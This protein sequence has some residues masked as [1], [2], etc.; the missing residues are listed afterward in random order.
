MYLLSILVGTL[1][2]TH[3]ILEYSLFT[4]SIVFTS[5]YFYSTLCFTKIK[6]L[7]QIEYTFNLIIE[8]VHCEL[9][10]A[11]RRNMAIYFWIY[12][13]YCIS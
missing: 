11:N 8:D 6:G 10:T 4:T 1:V 13:N 5:T 2:G 9:C 7:Q 12:N 3:C